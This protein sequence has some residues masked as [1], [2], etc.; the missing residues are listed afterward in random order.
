MRRAAHGGV[1]I[2]KCEAH[3]S[4]FPRVDR[5]LADSKGLLGADRSTLGT[6]QIAAVKGRSPA[7]FI[8]LRKLP[9]QSPGIV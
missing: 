6:P 5:R 3:F 9:V 8:R 2:E 7:P 4:P 1:R